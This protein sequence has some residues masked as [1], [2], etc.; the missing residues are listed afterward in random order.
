MAKKIKAEIEIKGIGQIEAANKEFQKAGESAKKFG[1]TA[2]TSSKQA[3]KS[4]DNLGASVGKAVAQ[5]ASFAAVA[6]FLK[7]SIDAAGKLERGMAG[8]QAITTQAGEAFE[9][10]KDN[11][12][13]LAEDGIVGIGD[14]TDVYKQLLQQGISSQKAFEFIGAAKRV[15]TFK[16]ILGDT[17]QEIKSFTKALLSGEEGAENLDPSI[18][19]TIRSLGGMEKVAGNTNLKLQLLNKVIADGAVLNKD[20]DAS[21]NSINGKQ[22]SLSVAFESLQQAVGGKLA[23]SFKTSAGAGSSFLNFLTRNIDA[24]G[25]ITSVGLKSLPI[26]GSIITGFETLN[27]LFGDTPQNIL[28]DQLD[29]LDLI[30]DKIA[31]GTETQDDKIKKLELEK[32]LVGDLPEAYQKTFEQVKKGT[33]DI[34]EQ[35]RELL[36]LKESAAA[37]VIYEKDVRAGRKQGPLLPVA[38][39]FE[40]D[41]AAAARELASGRGDGEDPLKNSDFLLNDLQRQLAANKKAQDEFNV[42]LEGY[43]DPA[44]RAAAE[45]KRLSLDLLALQGAQDKVSTFY[46]DGLE[47]ELLALKRQQ[48]EALRINDEA[49]A[50][51]KKSLEDFHRDRERITEAGNRRALEAQNKF[52]IAQVESY[53]AVANQ[54]VALAGAKGAS[55]TAGAASGL[56]GAGAGALG[57]ASGIGAGLAFAAPVLGV[58][59]GLFALVES[60]AEEAAAA[61]KRRQEEIARKKEA[62]FQAE[63]RQ[64]QLRTELNNLNLQ[65]EKQILDNLRQRRDIRARL[66]ALDTGSESGNLRNQ[67]NNEN[68]TAAELIGLSGSKGNFTSQIAGATQ[69]ELGKIN[70]GDAQVTANTLLDIK[71]RQ[72]R[73]TNARERLGKLVKASDPLKPESIKNAVDFYFKNIGLFSAAERQAFEAAFPDAVRLRRLGQDLKSGAI[74]YQTYLDLSKGDLLNPDDDLNANAAPNKT[75]AANLQGLLTD[76]ISKSGA[77][78]ERIDAAIEASVSSAELQ[79]QLG[80][81]QIRDRVDAINRSAETAAATGQQFDATAARKSEAETIA[82]LLGLDINNIDVDAA[83]DFSLED[84]KKFD[85]MVDLLKQVGDAT[86]KTAENTAPSTLGERQR[87]FFDVGRGGVVNADK[88]FSLGFENYQLTA[89]SGVQ[90]VALASGIAT[91]STLDPQLVE[92][93]ST[94]KMQLAELQ[95]IAARL[96][97]DGGGNVGKTVRKE[98]AYLKRNGV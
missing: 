39:D 23:S 2:E 30:N 28:E 89:P 56:A 4:A 61:E 64:I 7:S 98:V 87:T 6:G 55:G 93:N 51:G 90:S 96:S 33:N 67:I 85:I 81:Q 76:S 91:Q 19:A 84:K 79:N 25:E 49:T 46:N 27:N 70:K 59:A 66:D 35:A 40:F 60:G 95:K 26:I 41:P 3:A 12:K 74:D 54:A 47:N 94:A 97:A 63:L 72:E 83:K 68:K 29:Q 71:A 53:S 78:G 92:L 22:A 18:K 9:G 1:A 43:A 50:K 52:L 45:T 48:E 20:W 24:L 69:S 11:I 13:K 82:R 57:T 58:A 10:A 88:R 21:L 42:S 44:A 16:G 37:N 5:Y 14:L 31:A 86:K 32:K 77:Q 38:G 65:I 73:A 15:S 17:S 62:L 36:K 75:Q 80:T 8:L 34:A